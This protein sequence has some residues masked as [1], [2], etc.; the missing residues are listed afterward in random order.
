MAWTGPPYVAWNGTN[1]TVANQI[2]EMGY[3]IFSSNSHDYFTDDGYYGKGIYNTYEAAYAHRCCAEAVLLLNW[4]STFEAFPVIDRDITEIRGKV[5]P[6]HQCDSNFIPTI[7]Q[8]SSLK[9]CQN[10]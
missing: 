8:T 5:G 3:G 4:V 7:I 1:D 6:F 2:F 9:N 10:H